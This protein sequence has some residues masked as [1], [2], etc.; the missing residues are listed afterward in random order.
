MFFLMISGVCIGLISPSES[1]FIRLDG[2]D[3]T[4]LCRF[5]RNV[6]GATSTVFGSVN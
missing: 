3:L 2:R 4:G 5:R 1:A 6:T